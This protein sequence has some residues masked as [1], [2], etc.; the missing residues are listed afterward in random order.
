VL[1]VRQQEQVF[2]EVQPPLVLPDVWS[3]ALYIAAAVEERYTPEHL[4][5]R[6]AQLLIHR[7]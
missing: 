4:I 5:R 2:T 3:L 1:T 6:K 7:R